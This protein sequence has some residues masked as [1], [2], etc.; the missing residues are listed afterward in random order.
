MK[1]YCFGQ[2]ILSVGQ[3]TN[4]ELWIS[5]IAGSLY[6]F[7]QLTTGKKGSKGDGQKI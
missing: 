7:G 1:G 5:R 3:E 4:D 6:G 2:F